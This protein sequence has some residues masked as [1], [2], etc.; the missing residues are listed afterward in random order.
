MEYSIISESELTTKRPEGGAIKRVEIIQRL[1]TKWHLLVEVSWHPGQTFM[2]AKFTNR[3]V[4][5]YNL[6]LNA[7]RHAISKYDYVGPIILYPRK[8]M[9][10]DRL[11]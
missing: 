9:L 6:A 8:G 11:I 2:V 7:T 10:P 5:L 4:K 3:E 1:D